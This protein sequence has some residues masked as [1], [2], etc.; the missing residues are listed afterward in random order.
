MAFRRYRPSSSEAHG[1]ISRSRDS[2]W[3]VSRKRFPFLL[4]YPVLF[5][6]PTYQNSQTPLIYS[7]P[8]LHDPDIRNRGGGDGGGERGHPRHRLQRHHRLPDRILHRPRTQLR[9]RL[10]GPLDPPHANAHRVRKTIPPLQR[11]AQRQLP[12]R[13]QHQLLL[14]RCF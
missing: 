10:R 2:T 1:P 13:E 5:R 8:R 12:S 7:E 14:G 6:N 3:E 4:L 11:L 9:P